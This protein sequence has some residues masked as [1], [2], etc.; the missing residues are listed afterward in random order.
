MIKIKVVKD[1]TIL[2]EHL[3]DPSS[4]SLR[5]LRDLIIPSLSKEWLVAD[6]GDL[7]RYDKEAEEM[8]ED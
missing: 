8:C 3:V 7:I 4:T 5:Q 1:K 6:G 2:G